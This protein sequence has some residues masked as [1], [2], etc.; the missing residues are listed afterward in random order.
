MPNEL[1]PQGKL[2]HLWG[3]AKGLLDYDKSEWL[4]LQH[5]LE[6]LQAT[7]AAL[8]AHLA[9]IRAARKRRS[10]SAIASLVGLLAAI[11]A[12]QESKP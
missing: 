2:H 7:N 8:T 11:D 5:E 9:A 1:I 6:T 10:D 12:T 3:K 4:A